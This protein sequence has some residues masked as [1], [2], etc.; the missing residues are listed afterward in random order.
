M[1]DILSRA[2]GSAPSPQVSQMELDLD[3]YMDGVHPTKHERR[4]ALH[5]ATDFI[6]WTWEMVNAGHEEVGWSADGD[7]IV[8]TNPERLASVVLPLYFRHS[9]YASW[10]RALNAYNFRKARPGQWFHPNFRRGRP[11]NLK[12]ILRKQPG[13]RKA[14]ASS[15]QL[16]VR[17][18]QRLSG[19]AE[20]LLQQEKARLW[21]MEQQLRQLED[22]A[23]SIQTE[24]LEDKLNTIRIMQLVLSSLRSVDKG[25]GIPRLHLNPGL[26]RQP[27]ITYKPEEIVL[28]DLGEISS[29]DKPRAPA[30]P[31]EDSHTQ[32]PRSH[33]SPDEDFMET[34]PA[35][36]LDLSSFTLAHPLAPFEVLMGGEPLRGTGTGMGSGP[37][38]QH[39]SQ[40]SPQVVLPPAGSTERAHLEQVVEM[41]FSQLSIAADNALAQGKMGDWGRNVRKHAG[42]DFAFGENSND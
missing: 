39:T 3:E 37:S 24:D 27:R 22:E 8:V 9:Q 12:F 21:W 2:S 13:V 18:P 7:R 4:P 36:S 19:Q 16:A 15:T 34:T 25:K 28:G 29:L 6:S 26:L 17:V 14:S 23:K 20:S 10:V 35:A 33:G 38:S 32:S 42:F 40:R 11:E 41:Y 30:S 31:S 5:G 1:L